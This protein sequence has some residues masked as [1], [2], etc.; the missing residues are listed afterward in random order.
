MIRSFAYTAEETGPRFL[1]LGAVH[2]NETCGTN[3]ILR[4][5]G[6]LDSGKLRLARGHVVF[7]PVANPRAHESGQRFIERN[8]NRFFLPV[9]E[10]KAYEAKLNNILCPMVEACDV[11][12]DLHSTTAGGIPFASVEGTDP[13]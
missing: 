3:A 10:P 13:E 1:V 6:E 4:V 12:L 9:K 2:G 8:L 5:M 7:V 11:L